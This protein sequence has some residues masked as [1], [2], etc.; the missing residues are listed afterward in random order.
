MIAMESIIEVKEQQKQSISVFAIFLRVVA[1]V[2][3]MILLLSSGYAVYLVVDRSRDYEKKDPDDVTWWQQ[4][5]VA[6]IEKIEGNVSREYLP[7]SVSEASL[8]MHTLL[9]A[10]QTDDDDT[11]ATV[12]NGN[13]SASW[14]SSAPG[15]NVT[16]TRTINGRTAVAAA[17]SVNGSTAMIADDIRD[18]MPEE[19]DVFLQSIS[20]S[21]AVGAI[22]DYPSLP[23]DTLVTSTAAAAAAADVTESTL[24]LSNI[25]A[26]A[27]VDGGVSMFDYVTSTVAENLGWGGTESEFEMRRSGEGEE[28]EAWNDTEANSLRSIIEKGAFNITLMTGRPWEK[29]DDWSDGSLAGMAATHA[30]NVT[31][32]PAVMSTN[33]VLLSKD[34]CWETM[35]GQPEYGEFK[36]AENILHLVNNQ[37]MIWLGTFFSPA[38][39]SINT[40]KLLCIMYIRSW[41]VLTCNIP[42]ERVFRAS[43]SNNFYFALLLTMLFLCVLPVCYAIVWLEPS[44]SCG[45]F[46]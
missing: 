32:L 46:R 19:S 15:G 2:V 36:I 44:F 24:S 1:H 39:P 25:T 38:L 29:I 35:V 14:A 22:S 31:S 20:P 3:V 43:R 16:Y 8:A 41:A 13:D 30:H 6:E 9:L 40:L 12:A 34:L 26:H 27:H 11:L 28:E 45:P 17:V 21:I 37:G 4:N 10:N 42:H 7:P 23:N 33:N 5:E 18:I